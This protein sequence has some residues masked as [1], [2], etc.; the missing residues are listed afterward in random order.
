MLFTTTMGVERKKMKILIVGGTIFLGRHLIEAALA[1]GHHMRRQT[2]AA[3][4]QNQTEPLCVEVEALS[5]GGEVCLRGAC[6]T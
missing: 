6:Q 3:E 2:G 1:R 4:D 5:F